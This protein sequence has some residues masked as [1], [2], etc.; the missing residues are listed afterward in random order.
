MTD[1]FAV[2]HHAFDGCFNFRDIGGYL[3]T[4]GRTVRWGRYFRAGRQDRMTKADL[5]RAAGLAIATQIDLRRPDEIID[6]GRGPFASIG[7]RYEGLAVIPADGSEELNRKVGVGISGDRY[8]RYLDFDPAPWRRVFELLA[9]GQSHPVLVH[10][11]AGKD[12]TGV[13]TALTLS[14]L[15]VDRAVIE[16]DYALTNRDVARHVDFVEQGAG[17]P[18]GVTREAMISTAGVPAD[19]MGVFLDGLQREHGGPLPYLLSIGVDDDMGNAIRAALL[20]P[21]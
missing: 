12:R 4:D 18:V 11:T 5:A 17:L 9:D 7:A 6:Q 20:E 19:A 8:L 2:R 13:I 1:D 14:L 10:C 15:G 21:A 16:A 3:G